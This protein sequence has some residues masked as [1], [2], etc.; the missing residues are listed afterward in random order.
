MSDGSDEEAEADVCS[1]VELGQAEYYCPSRT[2]R[3]ALGESPS[4]NPGRRRQRL[5][6]EALNKRRAR[7]TRP[8]H[9]TSAPPG[10]KAGAERCSTPCRLDS[11]RT[12]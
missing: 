12:D 6:G 4:D 9:V 5:L 10:G 7:A 8:Q 3:T 11:T 1:W 2:P